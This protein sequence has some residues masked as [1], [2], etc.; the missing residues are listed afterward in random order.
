MIYRQCFFPPSL[1]RFWT[2]LLRRI[3]G[4]SPSRRPTSAATTIRTGTDI[5]RGNNNNNYSEAIMRTSQFRGLNA[6][7]VGLPSK[8]S[9]IPIGITTR[10]RVCVCAPSIPFLNRVTKKKEEK[11]ERKKQFKHN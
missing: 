8:Y 9:N 4:R 6:L 2:A 5:S 10:V 7:N 11:N 3:S 1:I